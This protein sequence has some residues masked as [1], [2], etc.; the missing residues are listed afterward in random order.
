MSEKS[1]IARPF[2]KQHAKWAQTL[3]ESERKCLYYIYWSLC[4]QVS[5]EKFL[6]VITKFL[7]LVV[8]TMTGDQKYSLLNRNNLVEPIHMQLLQKQKIFSEFFFFFLIYIKFQIFSKK[9]WPSKLMNFPNYRVGK[10]WLDNCLKSPVLKDL[11]TRNIVNGPKHCWNLNDN[12]FTIFIAHCVGI[13][14]K[15]VLLVLLKILRLVFNTFTANEKYSLLNKE[16]LTQPIH[17]QLSQKQ[18]FFEGFLL[19]FWNID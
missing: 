15:K 1:C 14:V 18:E 2:E 12:I 7:R 6:L 13:S 3:L 9:R 4:R 19:H 16:N 11:S 10:T 17:I 8:N 5:W